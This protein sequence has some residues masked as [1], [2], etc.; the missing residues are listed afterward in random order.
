MNSAHKTI[1][2]IHLVDW[3]TSI[4]GEEGGWDAVGN[5]VDEGGIWMGG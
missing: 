5:G 1:K 3:I 4:Q 2:Q